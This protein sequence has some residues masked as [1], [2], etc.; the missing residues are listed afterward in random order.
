MAIVKVKPSQLSDI[1][2]AAIVARIRKDIYKNQPNIWGYVSEYVDLPVGL[3][4]DDPEV[5]DVVG[6]NTETGTWLLGTLRRKGFYKRIAFTGVRATDY[7]TTPYSIAPDFLEITGD[8]QYT[9]ENI[10]A[11]DENLTESIDALDMAMGDV[12]TILES[13]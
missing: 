10:V 3:T 5:G 8:R 13:I 2:A 11:S 1:T 12:Q 7:G 4:D 6:V 9:E